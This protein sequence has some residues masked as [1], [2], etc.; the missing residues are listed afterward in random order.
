MHFLPCAA[1]FY[2]FLYG[3]RTG[4][5]RHYQSLL[6]L[7]P[8]VA[9]SHVHDICIVCKSHEA[10]KSILRPHTDKETYGSSSYTSHRGS[11]RVSLV[12][13]HNDSSSVSAHNF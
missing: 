12:S 8:A 9:I 7:I 1:H 6:S 13:Y 2:K 3:T 5:A 11:S 4:V 10:L